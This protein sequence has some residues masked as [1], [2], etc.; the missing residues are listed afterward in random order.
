MSSN[1]LMH[2][3]LCKFKN[4]IDFVDKLI[5]IYSVMFLNEKTKLR[6]FEK[7]VLNFYMRFG[8]STA[9]KKK[10]QTELGKSAETITQA[11]FF[12]KQKKCL[13]DSKT[14]FSNKRLCKELQDFKDNFID[15]DKKILAIGFKRNK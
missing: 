2:P 1:K 9:T 5:S 3:N 12:L 4:Q 13:I 7:D 6:K 11:T 8:Y 14:N 15:G 10:I